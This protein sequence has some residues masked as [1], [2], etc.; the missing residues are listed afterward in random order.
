[1][2]SCVDGKKDCPFS[3]EDHYNWCGHQGE[4]RTHLHWPKKGMGGNNPKSKIVAIACWP[5]HDKIDNFGG[6]IH[7]K[8]LPGK[9]LTCWGMDIRGNTLFEKVLEAGSAAA[10]ASKAPA[11]IGKGPSREEAHPSAAA[12]PA[13]GESSADELGATTGSRLVPTQPGSSA[14]PSVFNVK[15]WREQGRGLAQMGLVLKK[16]TSAWQFEVGDWFNEGEQF[17]GE[18]VYGHI[19]ELGF[20]GN[21]LRQWAWVAARVSPDTRVE[22]LD[23]SFSRAVAALPVP[24]QREM[25]AKARDEKLTTRQFGLVLHG[26]PVPPPKRWTLGELRERFG[27]WLR[28]PSSPAMPHVAEFLDFLEAQ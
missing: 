13:S 12:P 22:G 17:L 7:I 3:E 27:E 4:K 10:E 9:G 1:M 18:E 25:L 16:S 23:W 6:S 2:P 21:T 14:P 5:C 8:N 26:P 24:K 20:P 19:E 11:H 28:D 15:V